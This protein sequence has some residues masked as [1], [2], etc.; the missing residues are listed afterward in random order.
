MLPCVPLPHKHNHINHR[1]SNCPFQKHNK[2]TKNLNNTTKNISKLSPPRKVIWLPSDTKILNDIYRS[3]TYIKRCKTSNNKPISNALEENIIGKSR[4]KSALD[5]NIRVYNKRFF[6]SFKT[7]KNYKI[8]NKTA[9]FEVAQKSPIIRKVNTLKRSRN[10]NYKTDIIRYANNYT[11]SLLRGIV[12]RQQFETL[13]KLEQ[14]YDNYVT[15]TGIE[16]FTQERSKSVFRPSYMNAIKEPINNSNK[17]ITINDFPLS[18]LRTDYKSKE[19]DRMA[20]F[21]ISNLENVS[22]NFLSKLED[23]SARR[24]KDAYFNRT[25]IFCLYLEYV[26]IDKINL[27]KGSRN[28]KAKR[29][30]STAD[31]YK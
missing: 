21:R 31:Y 1:L 28:S 26:I 18:I 16:R 11:C 12:L 2:P 24:L 22:H 10:I 25:G 7:A 9:S 4:C 5:R 15:R 29:C 14:E 30:I 3:S 27:S 13:K 20:N 6:R 19:V 23:N 17:D 8:H